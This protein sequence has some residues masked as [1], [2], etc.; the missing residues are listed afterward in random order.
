MLGGRSFGIWDGLF[1]GFLLDNL[2]RAGSIDFFRNHRD[3]P[4][5]REWREE[6]DRQA[7]DN[8]E[9][10]EKLDRL[11]RELARAG[12]A[13]SAPRDP[14]Y[15]PPDVPPEVALAPAPGND[16]RTPTAATAPATESGG[17]GGG[18]WLPLLLVGGAGVAFLSWRR[19]RQGGGGSGATAERGERA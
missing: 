19:G 9:L 2:T 3:D 18:L 12:R 5:L 1:L 11:D 17:S 4:G 14:N 8:A 10:R 7:R 13:R 15:L 6:A 16:A